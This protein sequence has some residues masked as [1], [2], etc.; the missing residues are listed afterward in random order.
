MPSTMT[1][2]DLAKKMADIDI[3]NLSTHTEGGNIAARPMSNN[4]QV[5]YDGTSYY[6]SYGEARVVSDIQADPKVALTFQG[7]HYFYVAVEGQA[8]LITD[9]AAMQEH[10]TEDL[11]R[12]FKQGLDTPGLTMIQIDAT[13]IHY[14][15][16]EE[17]GEVKL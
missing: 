15:D 8:R 10:W 14:W 12:W 17:D 11:N 7:Q 6:F 3:A 9:K 4:G 16:G 2:T 13:R 1:L 5:E